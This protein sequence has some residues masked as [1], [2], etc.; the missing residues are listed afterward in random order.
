[1]IQDTI[2]S[3]IKEAMKE[4]D[5]ERKDSLR[6]IMGEFAR[7]DKKELSDDDV[8]KVLKKV[9]KSEKETL[10][11]KG[12]TDDSRFLQIAESYSPKMATEEEITAWINENVD[13]SQFKNKMQAMRPIMSHF[14]SSADG[15]AVKAILQKL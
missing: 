15:N 12:E 6:V 3:S 8:I 11:K 10:E 2:K 1:M 13:F 5:A 14:G 9:V 4:K 7:M